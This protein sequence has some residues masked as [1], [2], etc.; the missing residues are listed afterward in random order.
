MDA[1]LIGV[2]ERS[3]LYTSLPFFS[4]PTFVF[5]VASAL[6][7]SEAWPKGRGLGAAAL[8]VADGGR[9]VDAVASGA[10]AVA[11]GAACAAVGAV[12][13]SGCAAAACVGGA[14]AGC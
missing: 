8:A 11:S 1:S 2:R 4:P 3:A 9:A 6:S 7:A 12:A 14:A 10:A 5:F 13:A